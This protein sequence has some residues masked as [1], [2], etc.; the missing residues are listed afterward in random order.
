MLRAVLGLLCLLLPASGGA[1]V[2]S[3]L[4]GPSDLGPL[5]QVGGVERHTPDSLWEKIN[6]E[7]EL[8]RRFGLREA[9]FA[10]FEHPE[11]PSRGLEAAVFELDSPLGAFGVFFSFLPAGAGVLPLGSGAHRDD[12]Q[13]FLWW[14]PRF[15]HLHAHGDS[16]QRRGS[17]DA[18]LGAIQARLGA[19]PERPR[20]LAAFE[21]VADPA[22][23]R[24]APD[25]L[26]G[27]GAL[28][29]GLEG[30]TPKGLRVFASLRR[31]GVAEAV[32]AYRGLLAGVRAVTLAGGEGW[33]G[34]DPNLG[35]VTVVVRG[36]M[37]VGA[38]AAAEALE[39]EQALA[40]LLR[41]GEP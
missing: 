20:E 39:V 10:Y 6:G 26:L 14:G 13:A 3:R 27:R 35:P 41:A 23:V 30:A 12:Y 28:P 8:Y 36:E 31:K 32:D 29:P 17:L 40:A 19:V 24:Y 7:A 9:A 22:T 11:H 34:V 15:V 25:H 5:A 21:A 18:A 1:E 4:P 38:R 33:T 37:L 2:A 16:E